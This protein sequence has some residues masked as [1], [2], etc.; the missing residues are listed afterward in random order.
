MVIILSFKLFIRL[1]YIGFDIKVIVVNAR[2]WS[3]GKKPVLF[4]NK[5]NF[6]LESKKKS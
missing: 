4:N 6:E 2:A 3:D 5:I 1:G